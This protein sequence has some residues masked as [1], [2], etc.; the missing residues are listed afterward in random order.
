MDEIGDESRRRILDAAESL[1][2]EKGYE[3]TSF[4]DIAARSGISRGSIPWH[5]KNKDGLL[6]AV[7][8]RSNKRYMALEQWDGVPTFDEVL[9][10]FAELARS[11]GWRLQFAVMTEAMSSSG[12][13]HEQYLAHYKL[14][15]QHLAHWLKVMGVRSAPNREALAVAICGS[16]IG[17]TLQ[18][19][20]DPDTVDLDASF[21]QLA[22]MV[23]AALTD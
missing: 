8:E 21:R 10:Q 23:H 16:L 12:G 4:V 9:K 17:T 13:V 3:K 7:I 6:L 18:W 11:D 2:A 20:I 14:Q 19:Q 1:F 22:K 15:R 5:F